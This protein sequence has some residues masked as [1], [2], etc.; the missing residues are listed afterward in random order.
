MR[1]LSN[2]VKITLTKKREKIFYPKKMVKSTRHSRLVS[3]HSTGIFKK[4][5]ESAS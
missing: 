5:F 2:S 4:N 1:V 3:S